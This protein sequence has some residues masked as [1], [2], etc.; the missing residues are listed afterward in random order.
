MG[1]KYI[2]FSN[3]FRTGKHEFFNL[4]QSKIIRS[5]SCVYNLYLH[6]YVYILY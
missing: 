1:I 2:I 3:D 5:V 4:R 6:F